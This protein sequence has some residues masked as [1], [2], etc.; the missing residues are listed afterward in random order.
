MYMTTNQIICKECGIPE[1]IEG[2]HVVDICGEITCVEC[3]NANV[4]A[5]RIA[6]RRLLASL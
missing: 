3:W 5:A 2:D 1:E 4:K 6:R